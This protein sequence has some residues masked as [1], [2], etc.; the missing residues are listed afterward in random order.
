MQYSSSESNLKEASV[1]RVSAVTVFRLLLLMGLLLVHFHSSY[2]I[3]ESQTVQ[4]FEEHLLKPVLPTTS[5]KRFEH[6]EAE[7]ANCCHSRAYAMHVYR[8]R[9]VLHPRIP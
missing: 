8:A 9:L 3:I 7:T 2:E 5:D 6:R 4:D 1:A